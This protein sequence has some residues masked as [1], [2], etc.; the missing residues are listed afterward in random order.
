MSD[1]LVHI[2]YGVEIPNDIV[3]EDP[4]MLHAFRLQLSNVYLTNLVVAYN[5]FV[6]RNKRKYYAELIN[7]KSIDATAEGFAFDSFNFSDFLDTDWHFRDAGLRNF[8]KDYGIDH[9]L[10]LYVCSNFSTGVVVPN[11]DSNPFEDL[12]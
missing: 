1:I 2:G 8:C 5:P 11:L 10:K 6:L 4:K 9:N 12:M 3:S 7:V